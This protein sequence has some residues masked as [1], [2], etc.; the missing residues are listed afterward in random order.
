MKTTIQNRTEVQLKLTMKFLSVQSN[1]P[2]I[3]QARHWKINIVEQKKREKEQLVVRPG[4]DQV[5]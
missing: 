4:L 2:Y 3:W 1:T 5:M